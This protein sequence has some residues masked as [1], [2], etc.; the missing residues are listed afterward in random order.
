MAIRA[1]E[2]I[3]RLEIAVYDTGSVKTFDSLD[4]FRS[5]KPRAVTAKSTPSSE[6][7]S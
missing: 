3:L 2:D 6:L 7:C 4:Y 1:D 5:I